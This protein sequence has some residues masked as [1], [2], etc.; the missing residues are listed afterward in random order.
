MIPLKSVIPQFLARL[1]LAL[2]VIDLVAC[3]ENA[4]Y[5]DSPDRREDAVRAAL[6]EAAEDFNCPGVKAVGSPTDVREGN[7]QSGLFSEYL[8]RIKGCQHAG[9]FRVNC[10][11]GHPC[12]A[13]DQEPETAWDQ[14]G[15]GWLW[16]A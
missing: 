2:L 15:A 14:R 11:G 8:I 7:W 10:R 16:L 13:A 5:G 12:V 9:E 1:L 4:S 6:E 3:A